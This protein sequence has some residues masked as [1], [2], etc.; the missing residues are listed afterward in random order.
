MREKYTPQAR[1]LAFFSEAEGKSNLK[2]LK[3]RVAAAFMYGSEKR[4][5]VTWL[6]KCAQSDNKSAGAL[7]F[8]C[9]EGLK[10]HAR[11]ELLDNDSKQQIQRV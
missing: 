5:D 11:R 1:L 7:V 9:L 8:A 2:S 6:I 10:A 3:F 4:R